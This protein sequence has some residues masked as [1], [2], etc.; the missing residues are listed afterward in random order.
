MNMEIDKRMI[1]VPAYGIEMPRVECRP[2][3]ASPFSTDRITKDRPDAFGFA[4]EMLRSAPI[5]VSRQYPNTTHTSHLIAGSSTKAQRLQYICTEF[6][7]VMRDYGLG[8]MNLSIRHASALP[9]M[10][11]E[12][13]AIALSTA[14]AANA[15]LVVLILPSSGSADA[16]HYRYFKSECDQKYGFKSI[17]MAIDKL[18]N[19]GLQDGLDYQTQGKRGTGKGS[20]GPG[21]YMIGVALKLNIKLGNWNWEVAKGDLREL[22]VGPGKRGLHTLILGA[23]VTHPSPGSTEGT[24]SIAAVVGNA[25]EH[26]GRMPGSMRRQTGKEEIIEALSEMVEERLRDWNRDASRQLLGEY[27]LP[28]HILYYRDGVSESQF[29][30][31]KARELPQIRDAWARAAMKTRKIVQMPNVF[32]PQDVSITCVIVS[33][34]HNTRF[35]PPTGSP[36]R[37]D[38]QNT[39][40][41][42]NLKPGTVV[43]SVVTTPY[44]HDFYLNSHFGLQGTV[45][46]CHYIVL[47]DDNK[48][49]AGDLQKLTFLLC[50]M[51]QRAMCSVSYATPTYY[52]DRLC[53]RGRHYLADFFDGRVDVEGLTE[54]VVQ[55]ML[56]NLWWRGGD[57]SRKNPW[58]ANLDGTMFWL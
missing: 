8:E 7:R 3:G 10:S 39:R 42:G 23:D 28:A 32:I 49:T 11:P 45:R 40:A 58:H 25:D 51:Y 53:E 41:K 48:M 15:G 12:E 36:L 34:R 43:E 37:D 26:C 19:S 13:I 9:Q 46:P 5:K 35:Y 6:N 31:V 52:A 18:E 21:S 1:D 14:K 44:W 56:D 30:T 17:C 38:L 33:K 47:H 27:V 29:E 55:D 50:H 57:R 16:G 4:W 22:L 54:T 2:K 24:P 20:R